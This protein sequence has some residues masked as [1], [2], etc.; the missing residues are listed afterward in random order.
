MTEITKRMT[1]IERLVL[2]LDE[3]VNN[4][5]KWW[6]K[7][8]NHAPVLWMNNKTS[9]T[10]VFIVRRQMTDDQALELSGKIADL[11]DVTE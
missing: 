7:N 8:K 9:G 2:V 5:S 3:A 11:L 4:I 1:R 10:S 6:H